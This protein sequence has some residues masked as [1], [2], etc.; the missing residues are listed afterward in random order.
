M[1]KVSNERVA[2]REF[3]KRCFWECVE[4]VDSGKIMVVEGSNGRAL[5]LVNDLIER[6]SRVENCVAGGLLIGWATREGFVPSPW[7]F[8]ELFRLSRASRCAVIV[9]EQGV[10]AFLY[11]ND[12]LVASIVEIR[13]PFPKGGIV[14]VVDAMDGTVVGVGKAVMDRIGVEKARREGKMLSVVVKNVFDLGVLLRNEKV[15]ID[16]KRARLKSPRS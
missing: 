12:I 16:F 5:F 3:V 2:V 9:N 10:K 6:F 8:E 1:K 7:F 15:L 14:A 4:L 11:G 13:E